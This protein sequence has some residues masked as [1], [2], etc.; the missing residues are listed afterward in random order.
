MASIV[1]CIKQTGGPG[2]NNLLAQPCSAHL[3]PS[4]YNPYFPAKQNR[5]KY[6]FNK[7]FFRYGPWGIFCLPFLFFF[8]FTW[9]EDLHHGVSFP[10]PKAGHL[11]EH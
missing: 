5:K 3:M 9:Q 1:F 7:S 8:A 10:K 4:Q 11:L 2:A 6:D